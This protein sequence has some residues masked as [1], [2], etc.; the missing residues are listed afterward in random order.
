MIN[1]KTTIHFGKDLQKQNFLEILRVMQSVPG[2][3]ILEE[4]E[5]LALKAPGSPFVNYVWGEVTEESLQKVFSF[6]DSSQFFSWLFTSEQN[7]IYKDLETSALSEMILNL[8]RHS[9]IIHPSDIEVKQVDTPQLLQQWLATATEGWDS[10]AQWIESVVVPLIQKTGTV[11]FLG[12]YKGEPAA[13]S[14]VYCDHSTSTAGLYYICTR[15]AFRKKGLGLAV[16][17]ACL[18][19]AKG[20]GISYAVL[21]ASS[22]STSIYKKLGFQASQVFYELHYIKPDLYPLYK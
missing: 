18:Q 3:K 11:L 14:M 20:A 1:S 16:T 22:I 15:P 17:E 7:E 4:S 9:L 13:T 6:Y 12:V 21:Y 5:V 10:D 2:W 19:T 8:E